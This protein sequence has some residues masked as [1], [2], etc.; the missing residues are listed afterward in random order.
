VV[1]DLN[2]VH[3]LTPLIVRHLWQ[4]KTVF[5]LHWSL[6]FTVPFFLAPIPFPGLGSDKNAKL[7][8]D[9]VHLLEGSLDPLLRE[10]DG[11]PVFMS[12]R[13]HL[14]PT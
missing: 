11:V 6:I 3:F 7:F 2:I 1:N 8:S 10:L 13:R 14:G 4:L 5:F 9:L 12:M